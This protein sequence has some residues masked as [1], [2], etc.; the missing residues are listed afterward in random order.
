MPLWTADSAVR[1]DVFLAKSDPS[2]S[3][4]KA[5]ALVREGQVAVNGRVVRKPAHQVKPGDLVEVSLDDRPVSDTH[6]AAHDLHLPILYEDDACFVVNKPAG[7]SVHPGSGMA[8]ETITL[9]N[10][11]AHEFAKRHLPFDAS[12]VLVHRLDRET[13]GC[14]LVAKTPEA[15][16]ALQQQF[17]ERTVKKTYLAIVAG[18]PKLSKATIDAPVGRNLV[19]RTKMSILQTSVSR[20]AKTTYTVLSTASS[21]ALLSC[22][23][24]TGRTHQIRVHLNAIGHPILGDPTYS[25]PASEQLTQESSISDLCLHSWKLSFVS[26]VSEK[27]MNVSAPPPLLFQNALKHLS[28]PFS[29][30]P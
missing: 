14:L 26:P 19:D 29:S 30:K 22:D 24:H 27:T 28:L 18:V 3:R 23:L 2:I 20:E 4:V 13:T 12:F 10:G 8:P 9:L 21:C 11:I 1:L 15:H 17:K 7:T 5:G 6:I 16:R 25:S